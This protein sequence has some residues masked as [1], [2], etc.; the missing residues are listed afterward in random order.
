M[1][2]CFKASFFLGAPYSCFDGSKNSLN[3][4]SH[5]RVR[6]FAGEGAA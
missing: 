6:L 5:F 2:D 3:T 1:V 4:P